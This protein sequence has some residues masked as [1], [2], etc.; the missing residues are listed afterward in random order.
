ML[1]TPDIPLTEA[2]KQRLVNLL[3]A[4]RD[5]LQSKTFATIATQTALI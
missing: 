5:Q 2:D 3:K 1:Q 4:Q